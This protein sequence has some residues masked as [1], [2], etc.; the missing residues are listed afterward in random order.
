MRTLSLAAIFALAAIPVSAQQADQQKNQ[1]PVEQMEQQ[2]RQVQTPSE[3]QNQQPG[4]QSSAMSQQ[5]LR[6]ALE[7]AGFTQIS[8]IDSAYL[9][10]AQTEDGNNVVLYIDPPAAGQQSDAGLPEGSFKTDSIRRA[11]QDKSGS[12]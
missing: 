12:N 9:V 7:A 1:S 2:S 11:E 6:S 8:I 4:A 5:K 10:R 3:R